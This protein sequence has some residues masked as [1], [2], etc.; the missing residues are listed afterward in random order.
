MDLPP[1]PVIVKMITEAFQARGLEAPTE[2]VSASSI[3]F[4]TTFWRRG[5]F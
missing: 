2:R 1:N 3:P 5:A 4:A